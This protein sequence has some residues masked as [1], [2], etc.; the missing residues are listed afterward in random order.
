MGENWL[1]TEGMHEW[2]NDW[3]MFAFCALIWR[4]CRTESEN[5]P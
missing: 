4:P 1:L 2:T 5:H 3:R